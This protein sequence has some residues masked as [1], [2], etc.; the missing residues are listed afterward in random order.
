MRCEMHSNIFDV[1]KVLFARQ[2][3]DRKPTIGKQEKVFLRCQMIS[4]K[5][6]SGCYVL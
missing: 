4:W 5:Q 2:L 1:S 3:S 6:C